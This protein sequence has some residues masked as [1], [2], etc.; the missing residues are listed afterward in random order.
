MDS[1]EEDVSRQTKGQYQAHLNYL[2]L[3]EDGKNEFVGEEM[4][5]R[6]IGK[7]GVQGAESLMARRNVWGTDS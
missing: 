2:F 5:K 6:S 1:N 3:I 4:R 7:F